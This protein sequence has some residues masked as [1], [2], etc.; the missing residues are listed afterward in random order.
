MS[1][2]DVSQAP[3]FRTM[4]VALLACLALTGVAVGALP[5]A[6]AAECEARVSGIY[7]HCWSQHGACAAAAMISPDGG[8]GAGCMAMDY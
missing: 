6:E 7:V 2:N 8:T 3:K 4:K 1:K 5:M